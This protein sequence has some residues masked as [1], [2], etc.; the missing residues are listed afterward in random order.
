[1][2]DHAGERDAPAS[3]SVP[4][5]ASTS[6]SDSSSSTS[7]GGL[8]RHAAVVSGLTLLSRVTGLVRDAVLAAT[9]GL[10]GVADA[11]FLG[12]M[13]P[14]LFRRLFGEG[15]LTAAF[16]PVYTRLRAND[17]ATGSIQAG[18][19]AGVCLVLLAAVL[20]G[21]MLLGE[22]VIAG[23]WWWASRD[24]GGRF[25][26]ALGYAALMLPYMPLV[27]VTALLGG[28]LQV[29]RR[30][31]GPAAVPLVLN[32]CMIAAAI[33][34]GVWAT[35]GGGGDGAVD[36]AVEGE[37]L[38][39]VVS[40]AVA[41]AVL[42]AGGL[43]LVALW[44]AAGRVEPGVSSVVCRG[45]MAWWTHWRAAWRE[46]WP[47]LRGMLVV[48]APM[49]LGLAAFQLN[50]FLDGLIAFV[51]SAPPPAAVE[52]VPATIA[53]LPGEPTYPI[54]TGAVAAIQWAQRLYQF[55]LGVFGIAIATAIFPALAAAAAQDQ[56]GVDGVPGGALRA[57]LR[58]G[59]R[60]SVFIAL[61]AGVGLIVTALPLSR[62]IY[63]R[64]AFEAADSARV[65][66]ILAGYAAAVWAYALNHLLTR[67]YY[68]R[69]DALTPLRVTLLAVVVNLALNCV[70]IWPFG[71]AG[72]AY[73]SAAT[74]VMQTLLLAVGLGLS[75]L[76]DRATGATLWRI[77]AATAVMTALLLAAQ[78]GI[79][80]LIDLSGTADP[81]TPWWA[82]LVELTLLVTLGITTYAAAAW[83]LGIGE[84]REIATLLR[85]RA[86]G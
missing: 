50:A 35:S 16:I 51:L 46:A 45:P 25:D 36:G 78:L 54:Q 17:S 8:L 85:R 80:T 48:M 39:R 37:R 58:R 77:A 49:T 30:F 52:A 18:R 29:H 71:A 53:W 75:A 3:A 7:D 31:A 47:D 12:F 57:T 63:E 20:A 61:P 26:L 81:L 14:N 32:G 69:A 72:L 38:A 67:A 41:V 40:D 34:A 4:T 59:L 68:A 55:P 27:C 21:L 23:L 44:R 84:L 60:L 76:L 33:G 56:A 1:M 83:L 82:A 70:L 43:Q 62:V 2:T 19:F 10:G 64:G 15:A 28:V 13:V 9:L 11:F 6:A 66:A 73:A 86:R 65:A 22:A 24:G 74:A 79:G 42:V 5:P